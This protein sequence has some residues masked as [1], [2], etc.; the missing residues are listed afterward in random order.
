MPE[1]PGLSSD[2]VMQG[3]ILFL[4]ASRIVADNWRRRG[5]NLRGAMQNLQSSDYHDLDAD[6]FGHPIL[7]VSRPAN[8]PDKVHVL[9]VSLLVPPRAI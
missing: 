9:T 7:V 5:F 1:R 2:Q 3:S 4:P 6:G 8:N